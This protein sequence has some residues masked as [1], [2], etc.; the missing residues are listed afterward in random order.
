[1]PCGEEMGGGLGGGGGGGGGGREGGREEDGG[2]GGAGR[3]AWISGFLVYLNGCLRF[4][5]LV[6]GG[7]LSQ[8]CRCVAVMI[9]RRL[10]GIPESM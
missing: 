6:H 2:G 10:T 5:G 1:M 4:A 9:R 7:P 3:G 8:V